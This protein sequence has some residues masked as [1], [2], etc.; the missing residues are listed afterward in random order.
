MQA[1]S[2][3]KP[4][5]RKYY[6]CIMCLSN[7]SRHIAHGFC[8]KCYQKITAKRHSG[9]AKYNEVKDKLTSEYLLDE[10]VKK[11]RSLVLMQHKNVTLFAI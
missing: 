6:R 1:K 2:K 10:Y 4:W 3:E 8:L 7:D 11:E 5:S 9:K